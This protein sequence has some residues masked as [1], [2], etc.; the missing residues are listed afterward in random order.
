ML[1]HPDFGIKLRAIAAFVQGN[2]CLVTDYNSG[3]F[4]RSKPHQGLHWTKVEQVF[5]DFA[6]KKLPSL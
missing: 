4:Q 6:L 2:V 1:N 5:P 3:C